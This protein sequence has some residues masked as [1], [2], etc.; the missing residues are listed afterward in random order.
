MKYF[1]LVILVATLILFSCGSSKKGATGFDPKEKQALTAY[2][3]LFAEINTPYFSEN[4]VPDSV[5]LNFGVYHT[6]MIKPDLFGECDSA[7]K[8]CIAESAITDTIK[9]YFGKTPSKQL[10]FGDCKY[11]DGKY[12]ILLG[13]GEAYS[14]AQATE[15][16]SDSND[17]ITL[18][19]TEF[20]APAG[21]TGD[22]NGNP[23][24]WK[25][26][27]KGDEGLPEVNTLLKVKVK[28]IKEGANNRYL[29]LEYKKSEK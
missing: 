4:E 10:S 3:T 24:S 2:L 29:L 20:V 14:F 12:K 27:N 18:K 16:I 6:W 28:R 9:R 13:D 17:I 7:T 15:I 11:E 1:S 22:I 23:E 5:L 8:A 21:W 26:N 25:V 19:A